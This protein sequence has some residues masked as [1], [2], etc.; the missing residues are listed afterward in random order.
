MLG[1]SDTRM[2]SKHYAHLA[3]NIVHEEI[4]AKLPSF[5]VRI[6]EKVKKIRP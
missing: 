5:N 1:H 6:D 3:P 2:V 4:R